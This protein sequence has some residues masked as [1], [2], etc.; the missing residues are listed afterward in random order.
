ML[1]HNKCIAYYLEILFYKQQRDLFYNDFLTKRKVRFLL[2]LLVVN[3]MIQ[4]FKYL[5][6]YL[7]S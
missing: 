3:I 1:D 4:P 6:V 2:N 5:P 7:H